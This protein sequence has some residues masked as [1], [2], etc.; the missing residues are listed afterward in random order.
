MMVKNGWQGVIL[1]F[2]VMWLF[3]SFR[4]SFWIAAGLPVAFLGS[5]YLM[6]TFSLSINI[7][8]LVGLLMAIGIMMDDAI[9]IS[10]SIASHLDRGQ[11]IQ[12][13]VY[14]GVK[15][16][17][18]GVVSSY[19]TTICIFGSLIF[20]E[21]EM[22][23][24][25]RVVPQVLI[26]VLTI[27]LIEAFLILPSHL[28]HSLHRQKQEKL[29]PRWKQSFLVR[30]ERFRNERL[31]K[32]VALVVQWRYLFVG[33]VIGLLF[34]SF[35]LLA[36]GGLQVCRLP[37]ARWGYRRGE[38]HSAAGLDIGPDRSCGRGNRCLCQAP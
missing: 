18:P 1:V 32:M 20:L 19:L 11:K 17:L 16:V 37:R 3:F 2:A 10:E 29:P 4:Y 33:G 7:M 12:D 31:V 25:L 34:A 14:N 30:F 24:V 8:S 21:G 27:S 13:A 15:K 26:L 23:A 22:G 5:M 9:V 38:D 36:G 6:A 35:A 28:S